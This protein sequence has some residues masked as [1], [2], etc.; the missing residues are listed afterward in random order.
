[1]SQGERSTNGPRGTRPSSLQSRA[2]RREAG[3]QPRDWS[4]RKPKPGPNRA[5]TGRR[6]RK[7]SG[8]ATLTASQGRKASRGPRTSPG[9]KASR[10]VAREPRTSPGRRA[11]RGVARGPRTSPGRRALRPRK[12]SSMGSRSGVV[13][14][15]S[16]RGTAAQSLEN[17]VAALTGEAVCSRR[18]RVLAAA[19][20]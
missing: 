3:M 16:L 19:E 2:V 15:G 10:G 8:T 14:C 13:A 5:R 17:G 6:V 18:L 4:I 11:S 1:M 12:E 7:Q 9:R 20:R